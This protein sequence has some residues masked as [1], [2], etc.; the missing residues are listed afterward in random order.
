LALCL[1]A[2]CQAQGGTAAYID[3]ECDLDP[4]WATKLGVKMDELI[5]AQPEY[6][7]AALTIVETLVRSG[8]L[9][10]IIVDSVAAMTPKAE[11]DGEMEDQQVGL[12]AR[13]MAKGLRKTRHAVMDTNTCLVFINQVRDK[14]GF[15]QQGTISPGGRALKFYSSVR[16]ELKRLGDIKDTKNNNESKGTRVKAIISKNKVADPYKIAEYDIIHGLGFNNFG[17]TLELGEKY[18]FLARKGAYYYRIIDGNPAE[19]SFAQGETN[20]IEFL[21][22]DLDYTRSLQEEIKEHVKA[23]RKS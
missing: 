17:S 6:G 16:I 20:A 4:D 10:L 21:A 8:Q 9:D 19:K 1:V 12:Q 22:S 13:M 2:E 5:I 23:L 11:L 18:G 7:E 15:M 3:V 14:I